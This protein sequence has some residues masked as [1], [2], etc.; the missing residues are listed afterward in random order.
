[1][2]IEIAFVEKNSATDQTFH[3][4]FDRTFEHRNL[5][6]AAERGKADGEEEPLTVCRVQMHNSV[7]TF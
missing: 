2:P 1:M 5:R 3:A 6:S 7:N 4:K